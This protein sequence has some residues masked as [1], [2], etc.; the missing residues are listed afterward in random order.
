MPFFTSRLKCFYCGGTSR[1]KQTGNVRQFDCENCHA[2]NFL[3]KASFLFL[4]AT[5]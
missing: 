2:T 5:R 4:E 1:Q 3:D